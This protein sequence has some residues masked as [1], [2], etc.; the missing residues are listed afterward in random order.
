MSA[1]SR[2]RLA[3]VGHSFTR[4][5]HDFVRHS[6]NP[7][8]GLKNCQFRFLTILILAALS[9]FLMQMVFIWPLMAI[10]Y[11]SSLGDGPYGIAVVWSS[12][13]ASGDVGGLWTPCH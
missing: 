4:R 5:L 1:V 11:C 12:E 2:E 9:G 13:A 10:V 8:F 6:K 7:S 3:F